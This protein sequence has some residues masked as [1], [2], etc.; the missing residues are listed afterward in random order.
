MK[1]LVTQDDVHWQRSIVLTCSPI[2][3]M[4]TD[5]NIQRMNESDDC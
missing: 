1:N 2:M 4:E 3:L 5:V